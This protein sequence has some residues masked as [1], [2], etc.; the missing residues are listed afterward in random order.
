MILTWRTIYTN[1]IL[2]SAVMQIQT[3][4]RTLQRIFLSAGPRGPMSASQR[5]C[6]IFLDII[7]IHLH[8][9]LMWMLV[10]LEDLDQHL[11]R[12]LQNILMKTLMTEAYGSQIHLVLIFIVHL[13]GGGSSRKCQ[14]PPFLR[15]SSSSRWLLLLGGASRKGLRGW[16]GDV[17]QRCT[18][19]RAFRIINYM[20]ILYLYNQILVGSVESKGMILSWRFV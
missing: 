4:Y 18:L 5:Y 10:R 2:P 17:M 15:F 9:I 6:G 8:I 11:Q 13:G 14:K 20:L 16:V 19:E 3:L 1:Y 7:S 12:D